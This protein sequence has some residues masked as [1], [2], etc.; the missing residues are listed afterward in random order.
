MA[1]GTLR[2]Q[3]DKRDLKVQGLQRVPIG[4]G[5][6]MNVTERRRSRRSR[7]RSRTS[8]VFNWIP[9]EAITIQGIT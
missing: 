4:P 6:T 7:S 2:S 8:L 5:F 1:N 3:V 9:E